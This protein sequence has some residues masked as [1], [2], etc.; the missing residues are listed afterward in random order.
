MRLK[1]CKGQCAI[2]ITVNDAAYI[3]SVKVIT[4]SRINFPNHPLG[5]LDARVIADKTLSL[6]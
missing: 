6:R 4:L 5:T 3:P 1:F 2:K